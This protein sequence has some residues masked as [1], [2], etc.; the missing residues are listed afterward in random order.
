M[1]RTDAPIER[2]FFETREQ[3]MYYVAVARGFR[4]ADE[5]LRHMERRGAESAT[6]IR[7][8]ELRMRELGL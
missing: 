6:E 1:E 5:M 3:A 7:A 2:R 4:S 8:R